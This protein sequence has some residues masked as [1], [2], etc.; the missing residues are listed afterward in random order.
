MYPSWLGCP[1]INQEARAHILAEARSLFTTLD[2]PYINIYIYMNI[3][4]QSLL[5]RQ[6][7]SCLSSTIIYITIVF[8][9]SPLPQV[10][11]SSMIALLVTTVLRD[12]HR[13][14]A[15]SITTGML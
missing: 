1:H 3:F 9:S 2:F 13:W 10:I 11:R 4:E 7:P 8:S 6:A 14:S 15:P 5:Q 12:L